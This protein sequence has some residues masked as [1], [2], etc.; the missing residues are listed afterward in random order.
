MPGTTAYMVIGTIENVTTGEALSA[1]TDYYK[2]GLFMTPTAAET[3][4]DKVKVPSKYMFLSIVR[5]TVRFYVCVDDAVDDDEMAC[6]SRNDPKYAP[7]ILQGPF[8]AV[9]QAEMM[10]L[11]VDRNRWKGALVLAMTDEGAQRNRKEVNQ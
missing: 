5:V 1:Q 4:L 11:L 10:C 9:D 6:T 8:D 7:T 2:V 3:A